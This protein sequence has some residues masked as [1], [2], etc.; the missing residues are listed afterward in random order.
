MYVDSASLCVGYAAM[1]RCATSSSFKK[2]RS[3]SS[4]CTRITCENLFKAF[5]YL[6]SCFHGSWRKHVLA[7]RM[8]LSYDTSLKTAAPNGTVRVEKLQYVSSWKRTWPSLQVVIRWGENPRRVN[9]CE[10]TALFSHSCLSEIIQCLPRADLLSHHVTLC[11][12]RSFSTP[13]WKEDIFTS[14]LWLSKQS[15]HTFQK[16]LV[17][18]NWLKSTH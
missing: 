1:W 18:H 11:Q 2:W 8:L 3:V 7:T 13:S 16:R 4:S 12:T 17:N 9:V 5:E 6:T 10:I 14:S 15:S